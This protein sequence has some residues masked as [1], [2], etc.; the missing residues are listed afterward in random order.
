MSKNLRPLLVGE[1][2]SREGGEPMGG[3]VGARLA[4]AAGLTVDE[5]LRRCDRVN[6]LSRCPGKAGRPKGHAFPAEEARVAAEALDV[7]GRVVVI[8]G[9]R[10]ARACG[11]RDVAWLTEV[12]LRDAE[13]AFVVPHPSGIVRWYNDPA[14]LDDLK[15]LMRRLFRCPR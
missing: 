13:L 6:L 3:R 10:V 11:L 15:V 4:A 8:L 14:N 7:R 1:A 5:F 9:K 12:R 2:P